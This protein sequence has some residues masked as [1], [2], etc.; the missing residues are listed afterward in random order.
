MFAVKPVISFLILSMLILTGSMDVYAQSKLRIGTYDSRVIAVAYYNSAYFKLLP[1]VTERMKVAQDK[2]DTT[3][4][5]NIN[6]E[7]SLR[8]RMMHEQGFGKG[9]VCNLMDEIK[10]KITE[11]AK[12]EKLGIIVSKWELNFNIP[13]AEIVDITEKVAMLFEPKN[14]IKE[15]ISDFQKNSPEPVKDAFLLED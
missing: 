2:K 1:E 5:S 6:K 12:N 13:A 10:D 15:M 11:L 8:Q 4:V 9:S 3:E 7:M 14:N